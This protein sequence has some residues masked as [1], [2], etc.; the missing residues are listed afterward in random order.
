MTLTSSQTITQSSNVKRTTLTTTLVV[1]KPTDFRLLEAHYK[2]IRYEL[3]KDFR[4][5]VKRASYLYGQMHNCLRDQL[6]CPYKAFMYDSLDG[7]EK[8]VFYALYPYGAV[9][10][11]IRLPFIS[12]IP[13]A[14]REISFENL[15]LHLLLKLL[16][17]AY[18]HNG[19]TGCFVGQDRC[20][21]YAKKVGKSYI[22][23]QIDLKGDIRTQPK[24]LVQEIRVLG[25]ARLFRPVNYPTSS[26]SSYTYFGRKTTTGRGNY[27]LHLKRSQLEVVQ[28]RKEPVYSIGTRDGRRTILAYHDIRHIDASVGKLLFDF[29]RDFTAFLSQYGISSHSK[30]RHFS[31]FLPP[32][33]QGH[34]SLSLLGLISVFDNRMNKTHALGNYLKLFEELMPDLRFVESTSISQSSLNAILILQDYSREDFEPG[35]RFE[36]QAD[37]YLG[38]YK[39]YPRLPKQSIN[40]NLASHAATIDGEYLDYKFPELD[41]KEFKLKLEVALTQLYLKDTIISK[42]SV[43]QQLPLAPTEF[44]FLRKA[45]YISGQ[46]PY[47]TL[48][49]FQ[50]DELHFLDLRDP[51]QRLH[52]DEMFAQLGI[53]WEMMYQ[54]MLQK[55]RKSKDNE[56]DPELPRYDII[57]GPGLFIE[58]EDI[59]ERVLYDYDEIIRRQS[60]VK[61]P[62]PIE[63]LKLLPHYDE[64]KNRLHLSSDE[65]QRRELLQEGAQPQNAQEAE[66]LTFYHQLEEYDAFLD[67]LQP[68]H[69][70]ISF[71]ELSDGETME[72]IRRIF[73]IQPDK[74]GE[75]NRRQFKGYYQRRGW[76]ASEKE[77]NVHMYEG[78]WYDEHH[79]YMVGSTQG[80]KMQ[81]P[82]AHLIRCFDIYQGAEHF[83]IYPLL[84][85][86][87]VQFVRFNQYTVYPYPF[88]LIDLYA[89]N[90]LRFQ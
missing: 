14:Y 84:L 1:S 64:V 8:W 17:I 83:D 24:D 31:E 88:H 41:D 9:P 51:A 75:Y 36:S 2:L 29:I 27:F 48:L 58:L 30:E 42:R 45:R 32:K 79:C 10:A 69:P 56:E 44:L 62:L 28:Q 76:F 85:A 35:G 57:V 21:V 81:Q 49:Y 87:S 90:V 43:Q 63:Q 11:S 4:S 77:N 67:E 68:F 86:T 7:I 72:Q 65:L 26:S 25:Q 47:E 6:D 23:L 61:M 16:Q 39:E 59:N 5:K 53:D 55:Y 20:Y 38:L 18:I 80:M 52:R 82:R 12:E 50:N 3:P 73:N 74:N 37:P 60:A 71:N 46:A 33:G 66:S 54:H 19:K 34:L 13:L 22:C 15:D 70:F 78:I 89:K 40:V